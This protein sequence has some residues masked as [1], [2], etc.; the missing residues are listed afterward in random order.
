ML[1][2]ESNRFIILITNPLCL[3]FD[4]KFNMWLQSEQKTWL[5][6][7]INSSRVQIGAFPLPLHKYDELTNAK[8]AFLRNELFEMIIYGGIVTMGNLSSD[9]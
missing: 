4:T 8:D 2:I 9:V 7:D 5:P 1:P 3:V 6:D